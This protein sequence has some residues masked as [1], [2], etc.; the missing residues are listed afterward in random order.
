MTTGQ[1]ITFYGL[2]G[3][4]LAAGFSIS[5]SQICLGIAFLGLLWRLFRNSEQFPWAG[6]E[7]AYFGFALACALSIPQAVDPFKAIAEMRKFLLILVFSTAYGAVLSSSA[8]RVLTGCLVGAGAIA[9]IIGPLK[10]LIQQGTWERTMGFFSLPLTFAECQ[11]IF[12]M[13]TLRWL[14]IKEEPPRVRLL[15][16]AALLMQGFGFLAAFTRGAIIGAILGILMMFRRHPKAIAAVVCLSILGIAGLVSIQTAMGRK[17]AFE[18]SAAAPDGL[19]NIRLRIW[20][21]GLNILAEH[22]VFGVGMNN[23]KSQYRLRATPSEKEK[24]W[25]YG[26][27]HNTFLQILTMS[28]MFG[29]VTFFW[30]W[31]TTSR[32]CLNVA[33]SGLPAWEAGMADAAF[34]VIV[35]FLGS[36]MTEYSF[37][38]EEVAMLAFFSI[39]L[40]TNGYRA[41]LSAKTLMPSGP[42]EK[43]A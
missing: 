29:L 8:R 14:L 21:V 24:N 39:G 37:G 16:G 13:I 17:E 9:A 6:F 20:S 12:I 26:H 10:T 23:V 34:P 15:L 30:F 22:P 3:Y 2:I 19:K 38:D 33:G 35:A 1:R 4:A 5:L 7:H 42:I 36:G 11:M 31:A 41:F 32:W 18:T 28:G 27:L 43:T 25:V 40:L